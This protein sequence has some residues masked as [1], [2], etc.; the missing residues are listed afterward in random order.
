MLDICTQCPLYEHHNGLDGYVR[1]RCQTPA[2]RYALIGEAPGEQEVYRGEP[3]VDQSGQEQDQ[4]LSRANLSRSLFHIR[5]IV[6]CR[7]PSNRDPKPEEIELCTQYLYQYLEE[8]R[9]EIIG[10]IGRFASQ[11]FLGASLLMEYSHGIPYRISIAGYDPIVVPIYHPAAGLRA[12]SLM[13]LISQD[14]IALGRTI[15][16]EIQPR[17]WPLTTTIVNA[18]DFPHFMGENP[19]VISVDTE[20]LPD[21]SPWCLTYCQDDKQYNGRII[22]ADDHDNLKR[23]NDQVNRPGVVTV[24]H[25]ALFDLGKLNMMG[26]RPKRIADTMVMAY[27]L[28]DLPLGLKPLSYRLVNMVLRKYTEVI[29]DAQ[30]LKALEYL[31]IASTMDWPNPDEVLVWEKGYPRIKRPQNIIKKIAKLMKKAAAEP[32]T[33]IM[34]KWRAIDYTGGRSQV[35]DVLGLMPEASLADI[36]FDIAL[37][38]ACTDAIATHRIYPILRDRITAEGLTDTY[39]RDIRMLPM[40]AEMMEHGILLDCDHMANLNTEYDARLDTLGDEIDCIYPGEE[41]LNPGS[42]TQVARALYQM[43]VYPT[44]T[45]STKAEV[46]DLYR[47]KHPIVNMISEWRKFGKLQSTYVR[48]LPQKIDQNGRIHTKFSNTGT[49]TG[50]LSS[51]KPNLQNIPT[52][53]EEGRQ[54]RCA[55]IVEPGCKLVSLDYSQIEM[56]CMAHVAEDRTMLDMFL[57]DKDIHS[58][59]AARMFKIP[60]E[61][62]DKNKHRRPAKSIGFGIAYSMGPG[63][64]QEQMMA[65]GIE[66]NE[67]EC[68]DLIVAWLQ[69]YPGI[70]QYMDMTKAEARR[71][72]RV[73][74]YFGRYR[75]VPEVM[76]SIPKVLHAGLRQ[77]GNFPIQAMAQQIIKQAMGDLRPV[78]REL[79]EGDRYVC[80]P[81]IQIHDELIFEV[82]EE[83]IETSALVIQS[84][85]ESA[86]ELSIPTPVDYNIGN[87]W[88][89][90]K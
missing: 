74:D 10:A 1:A 81:L 76:S 8:N 21:G 29:H 52:R 73:R 51:S 78:Y 14:Y 83:I 15:R 16:R 2:A 71:N 55:F 31:A 4:Y 46:M 33:D 89:E 38:Y 60:V 6:Q 77:A 47:D 75:L 3:F 17:D 40:V 72:G 86:V 68:Q 26:V 65:Q 85:M 70:Y 37:Q 7:P 42:P 23:F 90:L 34:D 53:T 24:L 59:T 43:G 79:R 36:D 87:N 30:Q 69:V 58:E 82:S 9:P 56:R 62:V 39:D 11:W 57:A 20:T 13:T 19:V 25:N 80:R 50:R 12:T 88:G 27:L 63:K 5:N 66:Y 67:R 44:P 84:I 45:T 35:E 64:L 49:A 22:M 32:D 41:R 18:L 54:I 61:E 28:Q 48:A